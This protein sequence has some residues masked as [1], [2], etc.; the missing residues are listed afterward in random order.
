MLVSCISLFKI[1][2]NLTLKCSTQPEQGLSKLIKDDFV[3]V[4]EV[5]EKLSFFKD[6]KPVDKFIGFGS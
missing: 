4:V 3:M 6:I 5:N 2:N 1:L